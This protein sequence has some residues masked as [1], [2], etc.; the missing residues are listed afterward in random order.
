MDANQQTL[1]LW[2][3]AGEDVTINFGLGK[4]SGHSIVGVPHRLRAVTKLLPEIMEPGYMGELVLTPKHV[5]FGEPMLI[6]QGTFKPDIHY[7]MLLWNG[8]IAA[9]QDCIAIYS[10]DYPDTVSRL[11]GPKAEDWG[12]FNI[13]L[14]HFIGDKHE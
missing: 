5:W 3:L 9:E 4:G 10:H 12:T 13:N 1:A 7:N 14:F 6:V 8:I 2:A 11:F